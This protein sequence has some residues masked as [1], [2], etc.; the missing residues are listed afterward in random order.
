MMFNRNNEPII[1]KNDEFRKCI[2][3]I[4]FPIYDYKEEE[5]KILKDVI[6]DR[7]EKY[8]TKRKLAIACINNYCLSYRSKIS[9]IG[10]NAF[11]EFALIYPS[12]ASLKKDV[13]QD[14][15]LFAREMIFNPYLEN[16][17]FSEKLVRESIEMYKEGVKNKL[18][19]YDGYCQYKNDLLIDENDYLVS[20]VFKD[21]SLLSNV[22]SERLYNVYKKIISGPPLTFLIGNVDEKKSK[23]LVKESTIVKNLLSSN[24]SDVLFNYLRNDNDLVYRT[25]AYTYGFGTLSLISFTGSKNIDMIFEL[26]E[27]A[28]NYISD[29]NYIESRLPLF[30]EKARIDNELDKEE[31]STILFDYVDKYLGYSNEKYYDVIKSIKPLEVK[32]FIDN[33]LVSTLTILRINKNSKST[34]HVELYTFFGGNNGEYVDYNGNT[35]SIKPG[36]AHLLE[37]YIC[38]NTVEGNLLDNLRKYN[39]LSCNGGTNNEN[40]SYFFNTVTNFYEC[41]ETFLRGIYNISFTKEKLDKT[42][43][44]VYSEIRDDKN[45]EKN[46]IIEK[47]INGL[48]TINRKTLGSSGSV[49]SITIKEIKDVYDNIYIPCNQFLVLA[50]NFD[51]DKTRN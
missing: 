2:L 36:T 44:A 42:K 3:F 19:R 39:I 30:T 40:T 34:N 46:K 35:R 26:Y 48:F 9:F 15:L 17:A 23:E 43:M 33:R 20:K 1:I 7:S 13:L 22:T 8:D 29:I 32:D 49:K 10:N 47:K 16:G 38:E 6:F 24:N 31:L 50:G 21:L 37:H 51:Y 25:N 45:N 4:S 28:M 11:L 27:K 41:L 12:V 18:K 14:N 5:L